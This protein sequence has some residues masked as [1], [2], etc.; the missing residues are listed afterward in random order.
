MRLHQPDIHPIDRQSI[1]MALEGEHEQP[2]C[3]QGR[4]DPPWCDGPSEATKPHTDE[5]TVRWRRSSGLHRTRLLRTQTGRDPMRLP[6]CRRL[7]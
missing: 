3:Q 1:V 6:M 7:E 4:P 2:R 5:R